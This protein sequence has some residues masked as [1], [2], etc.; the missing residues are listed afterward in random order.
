MVH[1]LAAHNRPNNIGRS[2]KGRTTVFGT[3]NNGSTPF[4]PAL[5]PATPLSRWR[6]AVRIYR[7][8][9]N[10]NPLINV[11]L[12]FALLFAPTTAVAAPLT[13]SADT[14]EYIIY[15][16]AAYY[17]VDGDELYETLKC[18]SKLRSN[19][20]GDHGTSYGVA[21]IHLPAH[22]DISK[23]QALDPIW[24]IKWTANQFAKGNAHIWSCYKGGKDG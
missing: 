14:A 24:S 18:E 7:I 13:Y 19:A 23:A 22:S 3:V 20:V 9:Y 12:A 5:Q 17:A 10:Y 4:C 21:Q 1:G 15:A 11:L 8:P 16:T 6:K 2:S